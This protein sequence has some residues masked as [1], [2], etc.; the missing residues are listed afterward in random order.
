MGAMEEQGILEILNTAQMEE[1]LACLHLPVQQTQSLFKICRRH[2]LFTSLDELLDIRAL[3]SGTRTKLREAAQQKYVRWLCAF[4]EQF[5]Q[6]RQALRTD[7]EQH[8]STEL[9]ASCACSEWCE[10]KAPPV[11]PSS[12][13]GGY[14][15]RCEFLLD[16]Y[17]LYPL[18]AEALGAKIKCYRWWGK[19]RPAVFV[20]IVEEMNIV[21]LQESP[22]APGIT[23]SNPGFDLLDKLKPQ[24]P[25]AVGFLGEKAGAL[26]CRDVTPNVVWCDGLKVTPLPI[27]GIPDIEISTSFAKISYSLLS[28]LEGEAASHKRQVEA[29]CALG[30]ELGYSTIRKYRTGVSL[31]DCVW[32]SSGEVFAAIE[33]ETNSGI[34][35]DIISIWEAR[36]KL[37]IILYPCKQERNLLYSTKMAIIRSVPFPLI[38]VAFGLHEVV[39]LSKDDL[40]E[41]QPLLNSKR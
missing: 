17:V 6:M 35:K 14:K 29:M 38:L 10:R 22:W 40:L 15:I 25:I 5:L 18:V 37:G 30:E 1:D 9:C 32:R 12:T 26:R 3:G 34:K 41:R 13:G 21:L 11:V 4:F 24:H 2:G 7:I 8:R 16:P 23:R 33:V 19:G 20:A 36:P 39:L 28:R 27:R 31:V